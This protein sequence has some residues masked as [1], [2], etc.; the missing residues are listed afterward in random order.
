MN[1]P[2]VAFGKKNP[3]G[4]C[5]GIRKDRL[6]QANEGKTRLAKEKVAFFNIKYYFI[7]NI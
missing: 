3:L 4:K 2:T 7:L 1:S 5:V 6:P